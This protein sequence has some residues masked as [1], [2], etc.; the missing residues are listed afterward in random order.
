MKSYKFTNES[1][2]EMER[3]KHKQT[4]RQRVRLKRE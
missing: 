4:E 2:I 3:R 1:K